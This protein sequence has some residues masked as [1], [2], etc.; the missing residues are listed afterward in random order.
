M[1]AQ[2]AKWCYKRYSHVTKVILPVNLLQKGVYNNITCAREWYDKS[3][4]KEMHL[5]P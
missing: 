3:K 4:N 5:T 1:K 2:K